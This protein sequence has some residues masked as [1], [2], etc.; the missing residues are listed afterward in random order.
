V[1]IVRN[2]PLARHILEEWWHVP[3]YDHELAHCWPVDQAGLNRY[4]V[5]RWKGDGRIRIVDYHFLNGHDGTFVRH[6]MGLPMEER[7]ARSRR[8]YEVL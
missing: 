5:P 7:V 4:I 3:H 1:F 2:H 8:A 6:A